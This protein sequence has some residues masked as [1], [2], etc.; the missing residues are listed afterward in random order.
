M[1]AT[2]LL[3]LE[4]NG[5]MEVILNF[6]EAIQYLKICLLFRITGQASSDRALESTRSSNNFLQE[7]ECQGKY[8]MRKGK[9]I[10]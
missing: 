2:S 6:N 4:V 10:T 3:K 8:Q 7:I 9:L 5:T 1:A